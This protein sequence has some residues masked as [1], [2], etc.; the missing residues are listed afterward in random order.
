MAG[1]PMKHKHEISKQTQHK[2][3]KR[4]N[5]TQDGKLASKHKMT[6]KQIQSES[7]KTKD[8]ASK[9]IHAQQTLANSTKKYD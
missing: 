3:D 4:A 5:A 1:K 7:V 9:H 2:H 6:S 8:M